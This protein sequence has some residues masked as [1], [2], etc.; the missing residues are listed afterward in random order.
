VT[1][2]DLVASYITLAG[3]G[4]TEPPRY[5]FRE[6]CEAAAKRRARAPLPLGAHDRRRVDVELVSAAHDD[7]VLDPACADTLEHVGEEQV[8][9]RTAEAGGGARGEDDRRDRHVS[10]PGR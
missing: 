9:L 7:H 2:P 10:S 6:R 5:T 1:D 3:S 4:F 8:L